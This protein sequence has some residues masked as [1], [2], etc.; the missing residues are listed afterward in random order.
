MCHAATSATF[1]VMDLGNAIYEG[2]WYEY[3][4]DLRK[5]TV[6]L[7]ARAQHTNYFTGLKVMHCTLEVFMRMNN[8]ALSYFVMLRNISGR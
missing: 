7:I 6:L 1:D 4:G 3:P 5:N 2:K 8:T